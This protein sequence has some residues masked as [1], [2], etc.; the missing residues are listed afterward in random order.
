MRFRVGWGGEWHTHY[1]FLLEKNFI[2]KCKSIEAQPTR[3]PTR[4]RSTS[5]NSSIVNIGFLLELR[6]TFGT[7]F[8]PV[9]E[10]KQDT[11]ARKCGNEMSQHD[12]RMP[13][14]GNYIPKYILSFSSP[15]LGPLRSLLHY[16]YSLTDMPVLFGSQTLSQVEM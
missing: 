12:N 14:H 1:S 11:T 3:F 10:R 13:Q 16:L 2:T 9:A 4:L 7:I 6:R 15:F 5:S 8:S